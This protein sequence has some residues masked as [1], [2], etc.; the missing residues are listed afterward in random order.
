M[1]EAALLLFLVSCVMLFPSVSAYG[2]YYNNQLNGSTSFNLTY[3]ATP[4]S[5]IVYASIP[6]RANVTSASLNFTGF[7]RLPEWQIAADNC[8]YKMS[9][10]NTYTDCSSSPLTNLWDRN[11]DTSDGCGPGGCTAQ[12]SNLIYL[13]FSKSVRWVYGNMTLEYAFGAYSTGCYSNYLNYSIPPS[14]LG[15]SS[16]LIQVRFLAMTNA[17]AMVVNLSCWNGTWNVINSCNTDSSN[18]H[19]ADLDDI[20]AYWFNLQLPTNI[21]IDIASDGSKEYTNNTVWNTTATANFNQ[22]ALLAINNYLLNNCTADF[23][24]GTCNVP[25]NISSA[26]VGI[27]GFS[28]I[29]FSGYLYYGKYNISLNQENNWRSLFNIGGVNATL[30]VSC[31][32]NSEFYYNM[33]SNPYN[34][35]ITPCSDLRTMGIKIDYPTA[36]YSREILAPASA[37]N[38]MAYLYMADATKYTLLEIPLYIQDPNYYDAS[39]DIY[40]YDGANHYS[41]VSGYLDLEHKKILYLIKGDRYYARV[42][43][44]GQVK[45]ISYLTPVAAGDQYLSISSVTLT[46]TV[47]LIGNNI[48]MAATMDNASSPFTTLRVQ[49]QDLLNQ[50]TSVR[51]RVYWENG[52]T[53]YDNTISGSSNFTVSILSVNTSFRYAVHFE[54]LHQVLGN[55]PIDYTIAVGNGRLIDIG[56][57]S[58]LSWLYNAFALFIVLMT[59]MTITEETKLEGYVLLLAET[60]ILAYIGWVTFASGVMAVLLIFLVAGIIYEV[61][62]RGEGQ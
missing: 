12:I 34:N 40:K 24:T 10:G 45:E 29:N 16:D 21:T 31:M 55:S 19:A 13:N 33:T 59:A 2:S 25:F 47:T 38:A 11:Y 6:R 20:R 49:Y 61:K 22:T 23:G 27:L 41:I 43:K 46:P 56:L 7:Y 60:G 15:N 18:T 62:Y 9:N 52:S 58:S 51:I 8:Y 14:C 35:F 54:V 37:Y 39:I 44:G 57:G 4:Y 5:Q 17:T 30:F 50:T 1:K 42:T 26:S 36:S 53:F 28:A 48:L 32:D 3:N